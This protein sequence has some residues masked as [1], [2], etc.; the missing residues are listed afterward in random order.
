MVETVRARWPWLPSPPWEWIEVACEFICCWARFREAYVGSS[1]AVA[2]GSRVG[3]GVK[4]AMVVVDSAMVVAGWRCEGPKE[5]S[6]ESSFQVKN[7]NF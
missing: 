2:T 4:A 7:T 3:S 6:R 1:V 5:I